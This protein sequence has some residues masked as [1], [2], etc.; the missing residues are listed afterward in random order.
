MMATVYTLDQATGRRLNEQ[1]GIRMG[2]AARLAES[3]CRS[4]CEEERPAVE[5]VEGEGLIF[6]NFTNFAEVV[7]FERGYR[8][9]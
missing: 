9:A 2:E 7:V 3:R 4:R 6:R 5:I 8:N 1:A